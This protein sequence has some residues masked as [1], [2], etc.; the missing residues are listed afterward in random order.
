VNKQFVPQDLKFDIA[1]QVEDIPE[2]VL[3]EDV[4]I[5]AF[6]NIIGG[7][8]V[9]MPFVQKQFKELDIDFE[10]PTKAQLEQLVNSLIKHAESK[11]SAIEV[12]VLRNN[13]ERS[14]KSIE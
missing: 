13:L 5:N 11:L 3:A 12:K 10:K 6:C 2:V 8:E 9:G 7:Y 14:I 1:K 4:I